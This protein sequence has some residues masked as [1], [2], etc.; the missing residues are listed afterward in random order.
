[1]NG[2]AAVKNTVEELILNS[3]LEFEKRRWI[4]VT[5]IPDGV[6]LEVGYYFL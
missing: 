6:D 3:R 5:N 2:T 4:V 1:M